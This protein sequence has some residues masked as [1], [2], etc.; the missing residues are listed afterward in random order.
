MLTE[1][2]IQ[3]IKIILL[4]HIEMSIFKCQYLTN[5]LSDSCSVNAIK[6]HLIQG[7]FSAIH[8]K[9]DKSFPTQK[10]I[11]LT[12]R[13]RGWPYPFNYIY[14]YI[15]I[16]SHSLHQA[17]G[18]IYPPPPIP[19]SFP[20]PFPLPLPTLVHVGKVYIQR[21]CLRSSEAAVSY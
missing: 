4:W 2:K 19:P 16:Y 21:T 6:R 20:S 14:I 12:L 17:Q 11:F 18:S 7:F 15:Y 9:K 13:K 10:S 8:E 5:G 3:K 1:N